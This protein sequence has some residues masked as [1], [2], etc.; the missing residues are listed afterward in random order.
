MNRFHNSADLTLQNR[1]PGIGLAYTHCKPS[2]DELA[3]RAK[4]SKRLQAAKAK[5]E[6]EVTLPW[7]QGFKSAIRVDKHGRII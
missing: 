2:A 5:P 7:P 1:Q 6:R 4:K 3:L